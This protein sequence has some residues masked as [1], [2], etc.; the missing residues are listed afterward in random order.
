MDQQR[1]VIAVNYGMTSVCLAIFLDAREQQGPDRILHIDIPYDFR[2]HTRVHLFHKQD[3][4]IP[5]KSAHMQ[6]K[7][8]FFNFDCDA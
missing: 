2:A 4:M 7:M 8:A 6:Y 3:V 1:T 5:H